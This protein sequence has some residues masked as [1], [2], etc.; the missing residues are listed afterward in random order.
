M[1]QCWVAFHLQT[2][3]RPGLLTCISLYNYSIFRQNRIFCLHG[4]HLSACFGDIVFPD[5]ERWKMMFDSILV[6][7]PSSPVTLLFRFSPAGEAP[8]TDAESANQLR[9]ASQD[10]GPCESAAMRIW[11]QRRAVLCRRHRF[12]GCGLL[13]IFSTGNPWQ[14]LDRGLVFFFSRDAALMR[15]T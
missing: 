12:P 2:I 5:T 10:S 1:S 14:R 13:H 15:R 9:P 6:T 11:F 8:P 7:G 4:E 3:T